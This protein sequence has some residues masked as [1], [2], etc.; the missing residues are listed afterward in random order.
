M[1]GKH[2]QVRETYAQWLRTASS[3]SGYDLKA[4]DAE[5]Q[6]LLD[7]PMEAKALDAFVGKRVQLKID[8]QSLGGVVY[9]AGLVFHI[10]DHCGP[11]LHGYQ[12]DR[13]TDVVLSL[14]PEWLIVVSVSRKH[15]R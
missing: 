15:N 1:R 7:H 12:E 11:Y 4:R 3:L 9:K 10:F 14:R 5:K 6:W 8:R 13:N 2:A